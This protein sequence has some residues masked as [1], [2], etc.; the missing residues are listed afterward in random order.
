MFVAFSD[1]I[2]FD[3]IPRVPFALLISP[4]AL[5]FVAV[6]DGSVFHDL[7]IPQR[8]KFNKDAASN[9]RQVIP[10]HLHVFPNL[11]LLSGVAKQVSGMKGR[12][13]LDSQI[14]M[15]MAPQF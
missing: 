8:R 1:G 14:I 9:L 6:G 12:H 13:H 7:L 11:A 15:K 2:H 5:M 3:V 4:Q 10:H